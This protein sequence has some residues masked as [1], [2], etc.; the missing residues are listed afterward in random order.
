MELLHGADRARKGDIGAFDEAAEQPG[1]DNFSL[2]YLAVALCLSLLFMASCASTHVTARIPGEKAVSSLEYIELGGA[3]QLTLIRG[4]DVSKPILLFIHGGPGLPFIPFE[5]MLRGLE[6]DFIVVFYDQRGAGRSFPKQV[7]EDAT[8][9]QY[10][11]DAEQLIDILLARFGKEKLYVWGHSWGSILGLTVASEIPDK[12]Y[13]YIGMGQMVDGLR[14]ETDAHDFSVRRATE[15]GD[16]KALA[17]LAKL[18]PPYLD[19]DGKQVEYQ[20]KEARLWLDRMGGVY[21]DSKKWSNDKL[22]LLLLKSSEYNLFDFLDAEKRGR[23]AA[24]V[25]WKEQMA[26][27]FIKTVPKLDV[28]I[29]LFMGKTDYNT[30]VDLAQ[31]YFEKVEAPKGKKFITFE[32]SGHSPFLEEYDAFVSELLGVKAETYAE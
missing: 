20:L 3:R 5:R 26:V 17:A 13:A 25:V 19:R 1:G 15:R 31:E 28:P 30:S 21:W 22:I 32:R 24:R 16:T 6:K 11:D 27:N 2:H 18:V 7:E 9:R 10:V 23:G 4:E 12:L 29:Y 14:N 8:I